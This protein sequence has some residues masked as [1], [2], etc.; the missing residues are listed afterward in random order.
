M[1]IVISLPKMHAEEITKYKI[2]TV[3]RNNPEIF[4]QK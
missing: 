3:E 4:S 1:R 2:G